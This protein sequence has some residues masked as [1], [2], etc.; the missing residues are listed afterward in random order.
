VWQTQ[1]VPV[2]QGAEGFDVSP[3]G[4]ELWT[5]NAREGTVTVID[6]SAKKA[7]ATL[8]I[9]V[10]G[11]NRLKFTGDGQR[12]LVTGLG[13]FP[14]SP[15][16][17]G[18]DLVVLDAA[19]RQVV[20]QLDL[21][22]GAAGILLDPEHPRAFIAVSGG[23]KVVILDLKRLEVSGQIAPLGQPDGMAWAPAIK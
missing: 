9:P 8:P 14:P 2:G 10:Q 23:D 17:K 19:S 1:V 16:H 22:G 21:G 15:A 12:V 7:V 11:A 4:R 3:D 18:P 6:V 20:K 13:S 5:G